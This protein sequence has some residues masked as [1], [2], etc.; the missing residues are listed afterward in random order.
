MEKF[1]DLWSKNV[2]CVVGAIHCYWILCE[3]M[4]LKI[5][6]KISNALIVTELLMDISELVNSPIFEHP[7]D[8][9]VQMEILLEF[10]A[11]QKAQKLCTL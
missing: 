10:A 5:A 4:P 9:S 8:I 3:E 6:A 2:V 1:S 11:E 7:G